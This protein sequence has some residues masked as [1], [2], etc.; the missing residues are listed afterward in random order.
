[1]KLSRLKGRKTSE[2]ILREGDVWKG[3]TLVIRWISGQPRL[4]QGSSGQAKNQRVNTMAQGLFVGALISAKTEKSA[5]KRNRMRRRCK[6]A[7]R[8]EVKIK[9]KLPTMQ[10]LLMPRRSSLACD[11]AE[12]EEDVRA[13][14]SHV[15]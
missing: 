10:L 11:F 12:I 9:S 5:V 15:T 13:F 3:K 7:L 2:R 6:E 1:M 14:L 8:R 4:R